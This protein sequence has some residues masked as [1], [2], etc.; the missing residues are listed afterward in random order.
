MPKRRFCY[1]GSAYIAKRIGA[2]NI[3][4]TLAGRR[5][6]LKAVEELYYRI[7]KILKDIIFI[8]QRFLKSFLVLIDIN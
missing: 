1:D 6:R 8:L 4:T 7:Y 3:L 2:N 5:Q